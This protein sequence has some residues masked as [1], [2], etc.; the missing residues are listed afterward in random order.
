MDKLEI[1]FD[2]WEN[3][4][5]RKYYLKKLNEMIRKFK[6]DLLMGQ[7]YVFESDSDSFD[8]VVKAAKIRTEK[9]LIE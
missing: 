6:N 5:E 3:I 7:S 8:G 4:K 2:N 9:S 1:D